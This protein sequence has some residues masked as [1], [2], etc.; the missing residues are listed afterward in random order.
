[1][2]FALIL[3]A[4][5][6]LAACSAEAPEAPSEPVAEPAQAETPAETPAEETPADEAPAPAPEADARAYFEQTFSGRWGMDASCAEEGMF[7]LSPADLDLYERACEVVNL[8]REG[9]MIAARTQCIVEGQ[10]QAE[11]THVLTPVSEDTI[12]VSDGHYEWTRHAC[13]PVEAE[14]QGAPQ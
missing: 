1:M 12:T 3:L 11:N 8:T 6:A 2:R 10:P 14:T 7:R 13:G 9:D 5:A 4:G